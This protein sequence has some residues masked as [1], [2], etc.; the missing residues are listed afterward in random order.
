MSLLFSYWHSGR[1]PTRSTNTLTALALR[2]LHR[3][4]WTNAWRQ[5][6]SGHHLWQQRSWESSLEYNRCQPLR[7]PYYRPH[8]C[9]SIYPEWTKE[10][11]SFALFFFFFFFFTLK[12]SVFTKIIYP[13]RQ[14]FRVEINRWTSI[15]ELRI[16]SHISSLGLPCLIDPAPEE[17]EV[18]LLAASLLVIRFVTKCDLEGTDIEVA[19][20]GVA[21]PETSCETERDLQHIMFQR[22]VQLIDDD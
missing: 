1:R 5:C 13:F 4:W 22:N 7:H 20:V 11:S 21:F 18:V 2:F 19:R 12:I 10:C 9:R 15:V 8:P 16:N 3:S 17:E 6:A 14:F